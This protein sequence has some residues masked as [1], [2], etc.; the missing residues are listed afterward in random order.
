[1]PRKSP[2]ICEHHRKRC[3]HVCVKHRAGKSSKMT[4]THPSVFFF[5]K[6]NSTH[7]I[8]L[9]LWYILVD[10]YGFHVGK[11]IPYMDPH[12]YLKPG[13]VFFR[14]FQVSRSTTS[15][16]G[17]FWW[18]LALWCNGTFRGTKT[19][20]ADGSGDLTRVLGPQMV[21]FSEGTSPTISGK[22]RWRWNIEKIG[23]IRWNTLGGD[24][25]FG[26]RIRMEKSQDRMGWMRKITTS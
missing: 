8:H 25:W 9:N 7:A 21:A 3:R 2:W 4:P 11:Y 20:R 6:N 16:V 19:A 13:L 18:H 26:K 24:F 14:F 10:F 22:L 15:G 5:Q 12:G 1:M 23:Q 17:F